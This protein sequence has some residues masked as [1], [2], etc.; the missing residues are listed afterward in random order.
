MPEHGV[1][2]TMPGPTPLRLSGMVEESI[3]D[4]PGLRLVLF[5][6]GCPHSCKGCHNPE[7]HDRK[8]GF[9]L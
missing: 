6:Q 5:T 3:V 1:T 2:S 8:G 4:G 9:F 7:T